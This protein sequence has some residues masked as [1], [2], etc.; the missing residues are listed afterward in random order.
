M[1][2]HTGTRWNLSNTTLHH[3]REKLKAVLLSL[4]RS[5]SSGGIP[6]PVSDTENVTHNG[7]NL[8]LTAMEPSRVYLKAFP[9]HH[10]QSTAGNQR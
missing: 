2:K 4:L 7:E 3:E 6:T 10:R 1:R 5:I 9:T 8:S